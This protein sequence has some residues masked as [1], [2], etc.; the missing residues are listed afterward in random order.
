MVIKHPLQDFSN[1][2]I[3]DGLDVDMYS[4]LHIS[5]LKQLS[6]RLL[7]QFNL[8]LADNITDENH[9]VQLTEDVFNKP[10]GSM[11]T[12]DEFVNLINSVNFL[13]YIGNKY[14]S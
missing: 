13:L 5:S 4:C 9:Q 1:F 10:K 12:L 11:L 8:L 6:S 3:P 14:S 2:N 7:D